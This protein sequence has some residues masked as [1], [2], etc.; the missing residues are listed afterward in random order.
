MKLSCTGRH[1]VDGIRISSR[2]IHESDQLGGW[3]HLG[4]L[5]FTLAGASA[6]GV[7]LDVPGIVQEL[8]NTADIGRTELGASVDR[9]IFV[10]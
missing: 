2:G 8:G 5:N 9:V 10:S 3:S 1:G 6:S 7:E 4:R